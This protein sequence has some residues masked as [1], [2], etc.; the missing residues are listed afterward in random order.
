MVACEKKL[1]SFPLAIRKMHYNAIGLDVLYI[2]NPNS[3]ALK[4]SKCCS[5]RVNKTR[6][7]FDFDTFIGN[8]HT[9]KT[10]ANVHLHAASIVLADPR[11]DDLIS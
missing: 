10:S 11:S 5:E 3:I 7:S 1:N 2:A 8:K 9:G 6:S 4:S